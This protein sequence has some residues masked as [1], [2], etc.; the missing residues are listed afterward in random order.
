MVEEVT[1]DLQTVLGVGIRI[2]NV[3]MPEFVD[4]VARDDFGLRY[5][6]CNAKKRRYSLSARSSCP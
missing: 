5:M 6:R 2:E 4:Q 1:E 3:L